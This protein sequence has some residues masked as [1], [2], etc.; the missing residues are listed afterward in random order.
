M[1]AVSIKVL[2]LILRARLLWI[3][4]QPATHGPKVC[5]YFLGSQVRVLSI[6]PSGRRSSRHSEQV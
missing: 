6:V 4:Q 1:R 2:T 5:S 3:S